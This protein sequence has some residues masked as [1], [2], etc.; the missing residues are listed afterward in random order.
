[1]YFERRYDE[2]VEQLRK[3]LDLDPNYW[4]ARV[5]L[6]CALTKRGLYDEAV[7]EWRKPGLP[8]DGGL[9]FTL[10]I[11]GK[12][13]EA[14]RIL[15]ELK[16]ASPPTGPWGMAFVCTGRSDKEQAI[17]WLEKARDDRFPIIAFDQVD[18]TLDGLRSHPRFVS[19]LRT[20]RLRE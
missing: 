18:P 4:V 10:G 12:R 20:L 16:Q 13:A 15:E 11:A 6:S 8:D 14:L 5:S 17:A 19:L 3:T 2:A 9:G 7:K 1:M